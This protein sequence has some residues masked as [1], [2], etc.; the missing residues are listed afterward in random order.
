MQLIVLKKALWLELDVAGRN[1]GNFCR[2]LPPRC[3]HCSK[4]VKDFQAC[5]RSVVLYG[6]EMAGFRYV[7]GV[8]F[9]MVVRWHVPGMCHECCSLW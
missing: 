9:F 3:F 4:K 8:L 1:L 7:L 6:S 5:V 2:Y